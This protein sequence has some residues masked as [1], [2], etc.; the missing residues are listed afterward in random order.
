V[1]LLSVHAAKGLEFDVVFVVGCE[2]GIFPMEAR[3]ASLE[4]E[5][6]LFFVAMTRA[7][8]RLYLSRARSRRLR[9]GRRE[10]PASR[11]LAEIPPHLIWV[12][13]DDPPPPVPQGAEQLRL[14]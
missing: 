11:F 1:A 4:E 2:D 6:R 13:E 14:F 5:R 7:R 9:G 3:D 8:H 12:H 10:G